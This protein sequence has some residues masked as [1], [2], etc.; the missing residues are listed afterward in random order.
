MCTGIALASSELPVEL[1][2]LHR[3]TERVY[4]REG[5]EEVQFHWW[6]VPTV[7]PVRR[8][9]RLQILPWGT[10]YRRGPLPYGGW[11]SLDHVRDGLFTHATPDEVVIPANLGQHKG[12]W[13]LITEGIKG[14]A[15]ETRGGPVV[16]MLTEPASNYYRNMTEQSPVMP[17][18]VDQVI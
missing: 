14:V 13:F 12:T 15:I 9:G 3:L 2:R 6:Q 5:R 7:L 1:T 4:D 10:K 17:V 11:V 18:F 16:Y 8:N